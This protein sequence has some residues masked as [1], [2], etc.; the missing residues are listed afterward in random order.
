MYTIINCFTSIYQ[1]KRSNKHAKPKTGRKW[2][3]KCEVVFIQPI[4]FITFFVHQIKL[5]T[6][7]RISMKDSF[8]CKVH[9]RSIEMKAIEGE[10]FSCQSQLL[11]SQSELYHYERHR[12]HISFPCS[13]DSILYFI[14]HAWEKGRMHM[15]SN[16]IRT[17]LL[18]Q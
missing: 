16:R 1:Q 2:S 13:A 7:W 9:T 15:P 12:T 18:S 11:Y 10:S 5:H 8:K 4:S 3:E 17:N 6:G 14:F